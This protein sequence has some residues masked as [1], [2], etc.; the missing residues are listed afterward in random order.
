[1]RRSAFLPP[2]AMMWMLLGG[3]LTAGCGTPTC[4]EAVR[5][6]AAIGHSPARQ[7]TACLAALV[8]DRVAGLPD[9][10]TFTLRSDWPNTLGRQAGREIISYSTYSNDRQGWGWSN[11][12]G[13][14][15]S[16]RYY[17]Y[18]VVER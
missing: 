13:V 8:F 1:M 9:P 12:D 6:S 17:Q 2:V 4:G 14:Y 7:P 16:A 11:Y 18:G 5:C 15:R 10:E 3:V